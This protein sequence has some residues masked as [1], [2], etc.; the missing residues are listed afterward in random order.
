MLIPIRMTAKC[1]AIALVLA[2]ASPSSASADGLAPMQT[3]PAQATLGF[4]RV[5]LPDRETMGLL[6]A[7]YLVEISPGWWAGPALYGAATG[8]RGGLFT[9]G[10]EARRNWRL[11]E[12]WAVA[13]GFYA[14]GGGGANAPVGGGLML[15]PHVDLMRD[16]GGF[17]A[18]ITA[19]QVHFPSGSIHSSQLGAQVTLAHDFGFIAPGQAGRS[20]A[21]SGGLGMERMELVVGRYGAASGSGSGNPNALGFVGMRFHRRLDAVMAA[22]LEA[23]GAATGS[24]DGYAETLVGLQALWPLGNDAFRIG[25][26]GAAGLGGG[27]AVPTGGGPIAK[28]ALAGRLDFNPQWSLGLDAGRARALNGG[29]DSPYAQLSL[30]RALVDAPPCCAMAAATSTV[31]DMEWALSLQDV[32]RAQ[33]RDGSVRPMSV[34]G[35]KFRRSVNETVYLSGQAHSAIGGGAGAYS[36]GLVGLGVGTGLATASP[37]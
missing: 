33:R 22:T 31:H 24:A 23:A 11:G 32:L 26:R 20:A 35:L 8:R 15:R 18:G 25:V 27:G 3:L 7:S 19:S 30:G 14:G 13:A 10:A 2:G 9:W 17:A 21:G 28:L 29:F 36:A 1:G 34:L 5:R 4:E 12:F 16:F 6:G 37:W